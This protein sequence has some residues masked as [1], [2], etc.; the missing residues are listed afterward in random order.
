[1]DF[2]DW[3]NHEVSWETFKGFDGSG[4]PSYS[5]EFPLKCYRVDERKMVR[6]VRGEETVSQITL[7]FN[8]RSLA[9]ELELHDRVTLVNGRQP[10]ILNISHFYNE[11]NELSVIEVNL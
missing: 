2:K 10:S 7:Y 11:K 1:M 3:M 6:D 9:A 4:R 5:E 8:P